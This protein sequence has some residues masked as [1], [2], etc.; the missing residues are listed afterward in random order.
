MSQFD[1]SDLDPFE[2]SYVETE[3]APFI[4]S[5]AGSLF[6][7]RKEIKIDEDPN[8][9]DDWNHSYFNSEVFSHNLSKDEGEEP[10]KSSNLVQL[11][12]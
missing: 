5:E 1:Q 10:V 3:Q 11:K 8:L 9:S 7:N 12:G 6:S 4:S 2:N